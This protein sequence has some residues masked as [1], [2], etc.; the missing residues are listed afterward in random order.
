[1][2][3][4]YDALM[5]QG[6][7]GVQGG[8]QA[9][10]VHHILEEKENPVTGEKKIVGS[11]WRN[12][13]MAQADKLKAL[14]YD[15]SVPMYMRQKYDAEHK[16]LLN[17]ITEADIWHNQEANKEQEMLMEGEDDDLL[18]Q[19]LLAR[20]KA[21]SPYAGLLNQQAPNVPKIN[22]RGHR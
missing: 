17:K 4:A 16:Q 1:M 10:P 7:I 21:P 8:M 3:P 15:D 22:P 11:D 2:M 14:A 20:E 5:K 19:E 9:T 6:G 12:R 13:A 18:R